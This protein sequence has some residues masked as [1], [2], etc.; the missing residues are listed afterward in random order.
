MIIRMIVDRLL[1][2]YYAIIIGYLNTEVLV[3]PPEGGE[4]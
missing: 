1:N 3:Y 4:V 2:F